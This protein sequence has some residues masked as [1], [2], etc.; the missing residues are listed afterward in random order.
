MTGLLGHDGIA[1]LVF[2]F[3]GTL[4]DSSA[5]K[6]SSFMS[7]LGAGKTIDREECELAYATHGT[8]NRAE[9]LALSFTDIYSR[10]PSLAEREALAGAYTTYFR[11]HMGEVK[12]FPGLHEFH[13]KFGERYQFMISSNAPRGEIVELC[14][15]LGID[16]YFTRVYGHPV[17]KAAALR[18]IVAALDVGPAN[19]L[20]VGDR[21]EDGMVADSV[22]TRFCRLDPGFH[23]TSSAEGIVRSLAGLAGII[24]SPDFD[25]AGNV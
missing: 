20:Y 19:L 24:T 2:D 7:A 10:V 15:K 18:D 8:I 4:V 16:T 17:S 14:T 6:K 21:V 22:G 3:D 12:L 9:L 5:I 11:D 25:A 13:E 1:A 23:S